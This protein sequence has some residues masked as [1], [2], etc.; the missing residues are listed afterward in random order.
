MRSWRFRFSSSR[1]CFFALGSEGGAC[2]GGV[3][4]DEFVPVPGGGLFRVLLLSV[5]VF[6][7]RLGEGFEVL[8]DRALPDFFAVVGDGALSVGD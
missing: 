5:F 8:L 4:P 6:T 7:C 3:F 1:S 2:T